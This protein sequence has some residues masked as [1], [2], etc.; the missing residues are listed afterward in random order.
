VKALARAVEYR[1]EDIPGSPKEYRG[2]LNET[3]PPGDGG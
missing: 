2:Y 3:A 1:V